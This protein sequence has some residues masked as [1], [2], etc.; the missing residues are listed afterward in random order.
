MEDFNTNPI[1]RFTQVNTFV[2]TLVKNNFQSIKSGYDLLNIQIIKNYLYMK[3][4]VIRFILFFI[5]MFIMNYV[6]L[7][8]NI[9]KTLFS[10]IL[11]ALIYSV[12]SYFIYLK[13]NKPWK[14]HLSNSISFNFSMCFLLYAGFFKDFST[15]IFI[16]LSIITISVAILIK[17]YKNGMLKNQNIILFLIA[18]IFTFLTFFFF[19]K[20][21]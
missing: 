1:D 19:E 13:K 2:W 4:L 21:I 14:K 16:I 12:M 18:I 6:F 17:K 11:G 9:F 8:N 3:K 10:S 15:K 20:K 5:V 7:N